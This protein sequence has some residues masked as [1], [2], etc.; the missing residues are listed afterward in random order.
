ML[1]QVFLFRLVPVLGVGANRENDPPLERI[2]LDQLHRDLVAVLEEI[3]QLAARGLL[4]DLADRHEALVVVRQ[5]D[6]QALFDHPVDRR[7]DLV[8]HVE[9]VG[10]VAPRIV[11][12]LLHAEAD[13]AVLLVDIE[14]DHLDIV[15]FLD[16]LGGMADP[17]GPRHIADMDQAIDPFDDLDEG[18]EIGEVAHLA[19]KAGPDRELLV[20]GVPGVGL[21]LLQAERDLLAIRVDPEHL[22][23][24][25]V[26]HGQD[27]RW[28]THISRPAHLGDMDQPLDPLLE[29]DEG[30]VVHD[31]H[32]PPADDRSF[33]VLLAD[34]VP[35]IGLELLETE[36]N[37]LPLPVEL[38]DLDLQLL[39]DGEQVRGVRDPPPR[40]IGDMEQAV[41]SAEVDEGAE[42]GDV[43]DDAI[44]DLVLL[45]IDQHPVAEHLA[46]LFEKLAARDDDVAAALVDLDDLEFE[47]LPEDRVDVLD[48]LEIDLGAGQEGGHAVQIDDDAPFDPLLERPLH[49]LFGIV[50]ATDSV[51]NTDEIRPLLR[52]HR[53]AV[54]VLELVEKYLDL[55]AGFQLV[56]GLTELVD[57]D[58][59]LGLEVD[60]DHDLFVGDPDDSAMDDLARLHVVGG[61]LDQL[62]HLFIVDAE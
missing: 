16:H 28:V 24:H 12:N 2:D 3:G 6:D 27:F 40:H 39:A 35:G 15:A 60:I 42:I 21:Y 22:H 31:R 13:S 36:R 46:T 47:R 58:D 62:E 54:V 32:D 25:V 57:R 43:L 38:Q 52:E 37:P 8:A 30:A 17:F 61:A 48:R 53:P 29:F 9:E 11:A 19:E 14:N 45:E 44:A 34:I 7:F 5:I 23:V 26:A 10:H 49:R 55:V 33:G 51:P 1:A 41:D 20:E 18:T 56:A 59:P 50:R 4:S